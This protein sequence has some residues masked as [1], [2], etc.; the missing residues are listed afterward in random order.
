MSKGNEAPNAPSGG[1]AAGGMGGGLPRGS[2]G[3]GTNGGATGGGGDGRGGNGVGGSIGG[4]GGA[5]G[6]GGGPGNG[7]GEGGKGG[8]GGYGCD[9]GGDSGHCHSGSSHLSPTSGRHWAY[10]FPALRMHVY[11]APAGSVPPA[12]APTDGLQQSRGSESPRQH[13]AKLSAQWSGRA[14]GGGDGGDGDSGGNGGAGGEG[15]GKEGH[16]HS[17]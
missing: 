11:G 13:D 8:E 17:A 3:G 4:V 14:Y 2:I 1:G 10:C 7:G 9:G 12:P 15:G 6:V 16:S 5:G